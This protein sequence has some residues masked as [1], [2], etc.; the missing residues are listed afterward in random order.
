MLVPGIASIVRDPVLADTLAEVVE[1]VGP[2]GAV[3][4]EDWQR[5]T[6]EAGPRMTVASPRVGMFSML[7]TV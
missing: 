3:L 2:D 4:I 6:T 1:A 5:T 7:S